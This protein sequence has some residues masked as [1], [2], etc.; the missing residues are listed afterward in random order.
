MYRVA[1]DL[2]IGGQRKNG[3]RLKNEI[4]LIEIY[5]KNGIDMSLI[6]DHYVDHLL[7]WRLQVDKDKI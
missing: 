7:F 2:L 3:K 1:Q 6:N 5:I 4:N